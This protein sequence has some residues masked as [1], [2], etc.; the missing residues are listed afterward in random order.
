[1]GINNEFVSTYVCTCVKKCQLFLA[2]I[3][4]YVTMT[5]PHVNSDD[6]FGLLVQFNIHMGLKTA[7]LYSTSCAFTR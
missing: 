4:D 1:M 3:L 5:L 6:P 7:L 2:A